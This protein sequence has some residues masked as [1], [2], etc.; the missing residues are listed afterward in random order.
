M[1]EFRFSMPPL[2]EWRISLH[3][4]EGEKCEYT[5]VVFRRGV[6]AE[7]GPISAFWEIG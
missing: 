5:G 1:P 4:L 7:F 2:R 3:R 6:V